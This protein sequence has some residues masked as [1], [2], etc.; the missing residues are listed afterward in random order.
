LL[1][2]TASISILGSEFLFPPATLRV[3]MRA[4]VDNFCLDFKNMLLFNRKQQ[5]IGKQNAGGFLSHGR[6][7]QKQNV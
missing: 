4:G 3:A 2:V 6:I 1:V 5:V 7:I